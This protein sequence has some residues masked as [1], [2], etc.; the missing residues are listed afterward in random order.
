MGSFTDD[1]L[2]RI[3]CLYFSPLLSPFTKTDPSRQCYQD[4]CPAVQ[5]WQGTRRFKCNTPLSQDIGMWSFL[6]TYPWIFKRIFDYEWN[7]L[8]TKMGCQFIHPFFILQIGFL[9]QCAWNRVWGWRHKAKEYSP[10]FVWLILRWSQLPAINHQENNL[11]DTFEDA[12]QA[13]PLQSLPKAAEAATMID[14]GVTGLCTLP[15]L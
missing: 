5:L 7:I 6:L 1:L 13:P 4:H 15:W 11:W 10:A 9:V 3:S 14:R 2:W 8:E 12:F